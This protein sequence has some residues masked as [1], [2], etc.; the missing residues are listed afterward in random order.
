MVFVVFREKPAYEPPVRVFSEKDAHSEGLQ[1]LFSKFD[2]HSEG[3]QGWFS[4]L[5]AHSEGL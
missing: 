3:L 5:V 2:A 1:G 4:K